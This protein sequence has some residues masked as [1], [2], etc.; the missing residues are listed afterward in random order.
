MEWRGT[1]GEL[2]LTEL[3]G[4]PGFKIAH[5]NVRSLTS[6]IN[7]LR[8]DLPQSDIDILT[9]SET[10]L[11]ACIED[12]LTTIKNYSLIRHDRQIITTRGT[13]K[14]GGGVGIY[15]KQTLEVDPDK[16]RHLNISNK[17]IEIQWVIVSRPHTRKILIGN[18]YRPPDGNITEAF[19][20]LDEL[21]DQIT[22]LNKYEL[23]IV[24]DFNADCINKKSQSYQLIKKFEAEHQLQQMINEPTRYSKKTHTTIDLAFTN[25]K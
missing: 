16:F 24:G 18:V 7:Q 3:R 9:V 14:K 21:L 1:L 23:L 15:Y 4:R 17:T 22:D 20:R 25:I 10:W 8:L 6:K 11:H 5:L 13:V 19:D 2:S 12:R